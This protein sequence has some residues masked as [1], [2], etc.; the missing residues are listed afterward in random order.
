VAANLMALAENLAVP[1]A[2]LGPPLP[3]VSL[4]DALRD[5]A[6]DPLRFPTR[7]HVVLAD[8]TVHAFL[9]N[10]SSD[11][12]WATAAP[13]YKLLSN[14][15]PVFFSSD[16]RGRRIMRWRDPRFG[17]LASAEPARFLPRPP[18][19]GVDEV[20]R[21]MVGVLSD[22]EESRRLARALQRLLDTLRRERG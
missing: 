4:L 21:A 9:D 19:D 17:M 18:G 6:L 7:V 8:D 14:S 16:H 13:T 15:P 5:P 1:G 20:L 12:L 22:P 3:R 11:L 2:E 10:R